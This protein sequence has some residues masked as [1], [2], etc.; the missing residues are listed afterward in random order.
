MEPHPDP[1][2]QIVAFIIGLVIFMTFF[3]A[4][5]FLFVKLI[6]SMQKGQGEKG[7]GGPRFVDVIDAYVRSSDGEKEKFHS[8]VGNILAPFVD[9]KR[10]E[11]WSENLGLL[12]EIKEKRGDSSITTKAERLRL[13][14]AEYSE[15][16]HKHP[17]QRLALRMMY[18]EE[19][20]KILE[21]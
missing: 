1:V 17:A 9:P 5:I 16:V 15:A 3:A 11:R 12:K 18:E 7:R 10:L 14:E 13:L 8:Q 21:S 2:L 6:R 20:R 4:L 19:K